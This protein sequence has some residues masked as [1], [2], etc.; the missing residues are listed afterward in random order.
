MLT[1]AEFTELKYQEVLEYPEVI[2][3]AAFDSLTANSQIGC[4]AAA[5]TT[6]LIMGYCA[7]AF[8]PGPKRKKQCANHKPSDS[9]RFTQL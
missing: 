7:M 5:L 1:L 4:L 9:R 8:M 2:T 6:S 3:N